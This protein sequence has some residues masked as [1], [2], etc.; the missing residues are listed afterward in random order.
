[1]I[2]TIRFLLPCVLF[3]LA[4]SGP[5]TAFLAS[6]R[7]EMAVGIAV[8]TIGGGSRS[9]CRD[10]SPV[11]SRYTKAWWMSY[12]LP[13]AAPAV[14]HPAMQPV[15]CSAAGVAAA[16]T[17]PTHPELT[18]DL[19]TIARLV[20]RMEDEQNVEVELLVSLHRL[21]GHDP[22]GNPVYRT[23][24][25]TR[26]FLFSGNGNA[27]VPLLLREPGQPVH[28]GGQEIFL[29]I[30]ISGTS[31]RETSAYGAILLSSELDAATIYLD[32]GAAGHLEAGQEILLEN[33]LAG[34]HLLE[35][36][37]ATGR[38]VRRAV[39]VRPDRTN[40]AHLNDPNSASQTDGSRLEPLG[41]NDQG[42][43]EYRRRA[44]GAVVVRVPAGE[45]LM[46][47]KETERTP[48]E[49]RVF[50]SDFFM[51][52]T[53]VT[54]SQFRKFAA[55][56]G[57]PLPPFPPYWGFIKDHPAVYVTWSEAKNYCEWAWGRLPTEAEREKAARGSDGRKYPWG[58]REP[59]PGLAQFRK[60]WGYHSTAPVGSFPAGASPYGHLDMGGNVWEWCS[61][62]YA[63]DYYE[64][65]PY[66]NPQGPDSGITHVV[67]GGSWDS[68]P[69]VLSASC[70]SWGHPGYRDG[71]FG[72][73]CAMNAPR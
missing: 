57:T 68:R 64:M 19:T 70:R 73:R 39:R 30:A 35:L 52:Q 63:D 61:D 58:D 55:A 16:G 54:W 53:G 23:S 11:E 47:N 3:Q 12:S 41:A 32:G 46:G 38:Q 69:A 4:L 62:W 60:S 27:W 31:A 42:F 14:Q 59:E 17:E 24:Q 6:D 51:D 71:D 26:N 10:S 20:R 48:L 13:L 45:F 50:V 7:I 15:T 65:S 25:L 56:T 9:Y 28:S 33:V 34:M 43:D 1:M 49:H 5:A 36:H 44:D 2:S 18:A 37:D 66:R 8:Q 72:F 29:R 22:Q 40:V 67:R 21:T